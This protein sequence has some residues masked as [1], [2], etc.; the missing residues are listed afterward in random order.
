VCEVTHHVIGVLARRG[1]EVDGM[2]VGFG[3]DSCPRL[4]AEVEFNRTAQ[5][6]FG[7]EHLVRQEVAQ[8]QLIAL[9]EGAGVDE[10]LAR[11]GQTHVAC[12]VD[13]E[14]DLWVEGVSAQVVAHGRMW[15][16]VHAAVRRS[17]PDRP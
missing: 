11:I 15:S 1:Q 8:Q 16:P 5:G 6:G 14:D 17:I 7:A 3:N 4:V 12:F 13:F 10:R 2:A 9:F